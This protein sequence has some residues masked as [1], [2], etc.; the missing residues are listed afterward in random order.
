MFY[1]DQLSTDKE[2]MD[3]F[4]MG[5]SVSVWPVPESVAKGQYGGAKG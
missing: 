3:E 5:K 2:A 1:A 4:N